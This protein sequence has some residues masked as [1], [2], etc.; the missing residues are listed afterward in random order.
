MELH[1]PHHYLIFSPHELTLPYVFNLCFLLLDKCLCVVMF[2]YENGITYYLLS[3][4]YAFCFL[5][6]QK[7]KHNYNK[8]MVKFR[9]SPAN[10][11]VTEDSD[12]PR[13]RG[14]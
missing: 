11:K 8:D 3:T 10:A 14:E 6:I 13:G 7:F 2:S 1:S 9:I 12:R 4:V 5:F